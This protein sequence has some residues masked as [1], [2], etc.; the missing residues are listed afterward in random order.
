MPKRVF[1]AVLIER[2]IH[3]LA[4]QSL[5]NVAAHA[6]QKGYMRLGA[7]Y[8]RTDVVRN[9]LVKTF[10]ERTTQPTDTLVMLDNDHLFPDDI[11]TRLVSHDKPVVGALAFRRGEPYFPCAFV[12]NN[13]GALTVMESYPKGLIEV[14]LTGT[15]A[16]AIQRQVF[17]TL[18]EAGYPWPFFRYIYKAGEEV[19]PS[20]DIYF[21][22]CCEAA[23][24]QHY[25]DTTLVIPHLTDGQ[26]DETSWQM[27]VQE[28]RAEI[29][30]PDFD[31]GTLFAPKQ[32]A[33]TE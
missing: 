6:A 28:H 16:V 11:L 8:T 9:L 3:Q 26:V 2:T 18:D 4:F 19:L 24:I 12:R 1:W 15:G 23:D 10:L 14:S 13:H 27:W 22:E 17:T 33:A 25:L 30:S 31:Q 5:M 7:P 21:G 32:K 20:E 29:D